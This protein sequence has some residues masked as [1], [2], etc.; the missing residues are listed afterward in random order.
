MTKITT[1]FW[2]LG[3]VVLTNAWDRDQRVRVLAEFGITSKAELDEFGDRHR[4]VAASFEVGK[5]TLD[6]YLE[7]TL[8]GF[9][10]R[11][12]IQDF[13]QK[14]FDQSLP[15]SGFD[16]LKNVASTGRYFLATLN[17]ESRE[18]NEYRIQQFELKKFFRAFFS[19]C[20]LSTMKPSQDMYQL[21][22]SITQR[23]PDE[24]LF[25]DDRVQNVEAARR[26]GLHA[27]RYEDPAQLR[28][29][30]A[31]HDVLA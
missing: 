3:G 23:R 13:K 24:C 4:E 12:S 6:D 11:F 29:Q 25:I 26:C 8:F 19:S 1:I 20:Y 9:T 30:L 31:A 28:E 22:L 27:I 10:R 16:I 17:N 14:M 21:A 5:C 18:L 15:L 7:M 2:D